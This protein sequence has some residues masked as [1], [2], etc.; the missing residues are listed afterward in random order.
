MS[1]NGGDNNQQCGGS[2]DMASSKKEC[3]SCDQNDNI[4]NI[5]KGIDSMA[6][7]TDMSK[8]ASCGKEGNGGDMNTCNKCKSV[9]Y[10]NAACKKKHRKKHKKACE[11]RVAEL[12]DEKLFKDVEPEECPICMLPHQ[13]GAST[14]ATC[15]GKRI[16]NGCT[17]AMVM[18]EGKDICPFCRTPE[19][20]SEED[21]IKR[22]NR[23]I[24]SGNAEAHF[25]LGVH[26]E[27]GLKGLSQDIQKANE[28][29]LKAGELGYAAAYCNLGRSYYH[30]GGVEID[31]KKGKHYYELAAMSGSVNARYNLGVAEM[32]AGN[33][34]RAYKHFI[35]AARA[36][37]DDSLDEVRVVYMTGL[38]FVT[39]DEYA[40]T[41]QAYRERQKEMKSE[42][43]D[44]AAIIKAS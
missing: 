13:T 17:L 39:K 32:V 3:T 23:L 34:E 9:K 28:L 36:G 26:Y 5:T 33:I 24:K 19:S 2:G 41:V 21:N 42:M 15:C 43:R 12:H 7:L 6:L 10:C 37:C 40:S 4:D 22:L 44:K 18:S 1:S 14:F 20:Y 31:K 11:R 35:I 8:C 30:G 29:F 16:C 38:G 25:I 27:I